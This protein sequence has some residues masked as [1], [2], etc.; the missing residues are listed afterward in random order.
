FDVALDP[1]S[2][3]CRFKPTA[4]L[5]EETSQGVSA[6]LFDASATDKLTGVR[7][8]WISLPE[9]LGPLPFDLLWHRQLQLLDS[10]GAWTVHRLTELAA[11]R[12]RPAPPTIELLP[13]PYSTLETRYALVQVAE[14]DPAARARFLAL[15][16]KARAA[17]KDAGAAV[18]EAKLALR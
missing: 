3:A 6:A 11:A 18:R 4:E 9:P 8:L 5:L 2:D 12:A 17:G 16:A 7:R 13:S 1:F 15:V 14:V 10:F